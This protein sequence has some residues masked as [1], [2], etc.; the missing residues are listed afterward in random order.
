M[1]LY[2]LNKADLFGVL[3]GFRVYECMFG[4]VR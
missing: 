2:L 1:I 4:L 3:L